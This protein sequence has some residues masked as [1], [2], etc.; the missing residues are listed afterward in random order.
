VN[1]LPPTIERLREDLAKS[2]STREIAN[3]P[4]LTTLRAD[5]RY[6]KAINK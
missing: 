2:Y 3:E 4:E 5:P 1:R 6:Y